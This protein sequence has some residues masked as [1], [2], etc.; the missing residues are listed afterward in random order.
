MRKLVAAL[1]VLAVA[2]VMGCQ[3]TKKMT[4]LQGQLDTANQKITEL[5]TQLGTVTAEKDSL[6]KLVTEMAAKLAP[7]TGGTKTGGTKTGGTG[8]GTLKPPTKK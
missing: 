3:D 5:Q 1:A 6:G 7:K 2:F 8:G 4:E